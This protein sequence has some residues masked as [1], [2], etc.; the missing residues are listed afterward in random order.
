MVVCVHG[1]VCMWCSEYVCRV[2]GVCLVWC[3]Y[4]W[5]VYMVWCVDVDVWDVC[6]CHE[7]VSRQLSMGSLHSGVRREGCPEVICST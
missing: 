5:C 6:A 1:G 7:P 4:V 3:V 2:Y